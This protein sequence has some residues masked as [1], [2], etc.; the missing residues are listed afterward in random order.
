MCIEDSLY[1]TKYRNSIVMFN[2]CIIFPPLILFL[3]LSYSTL[4]SWYLAARPPLPV[5]MV[6]AAQPPVA[7]PQGRPPPVG[8]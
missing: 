5:L 2:P 7:S 1:V 3:P 4:S 8:R 6:G